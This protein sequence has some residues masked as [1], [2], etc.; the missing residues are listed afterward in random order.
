MN[1]S[2]FFF[3]SNFLRSSS[4]LFGLTRRQSFKAIQELNE[5]QEVVQVKC[6]MKIICA[7]SSRI[8]M[9]IFIFLSKQLE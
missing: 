5:E 8:I 3:I 2:E 4:S 7:G 6:L 1:G 9:I